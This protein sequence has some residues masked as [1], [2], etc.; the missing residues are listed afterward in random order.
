MGVDAAQVNS[1]L[2]ASEESEALEADREGAAGVRLRHP[3]AARPSRSS[4]RRSAGNKI[5][6][7]VIDEAHCIS[8]WGHDFRPGL[9]AP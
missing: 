9:P 6:V 3:R 8:E 5:D 1:T 7:F 2:T 4:W